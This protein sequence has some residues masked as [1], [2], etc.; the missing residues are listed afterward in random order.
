MIRPADVAEALIAIVLFGAT[1]YL[2]AIIPFDRVM[3]H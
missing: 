1:L 2:L 3:F